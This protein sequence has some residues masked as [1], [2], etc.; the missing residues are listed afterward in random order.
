[1]LNLELEQQLSSYCGEVQDSCLATIML[2]G[3]ASAVPNPPASQT[4]LKKTNNGADQ[5]SGLVHMLSAV[6]PLGSTR[7]EC[8]AVVQKAGLEPW[9]PRCCTQSSLSDCRQCLSRSELGSGRD[10][11]RFL[12]AHTECRNAGRG[13]CARSPGEGN[14]MIADAGQ[15]RRMRGRLGHGGQ[16]L[17]S[18]SSR[19][20]L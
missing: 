13:P 18:A 16:G 6:Q 14:V 12:P 17:V 1:M 4:I 8:L 2:A 11:P 20:Y 7:V 5:G 3:H 10:G 19:L 9:P 15:I